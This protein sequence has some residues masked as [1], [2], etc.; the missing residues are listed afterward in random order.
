MYG[1]MRAKLESPMMSHLSL[2][3]KVQAVIFLVVGVCLSV[4]AGSDGEA[5]LRGLW[6]CARV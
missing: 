2:G 3:V 5:K 1:G 4:L 6:T